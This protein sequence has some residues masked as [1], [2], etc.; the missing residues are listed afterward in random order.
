MRFSIRT[1]CVSIVLS[2]LSLVVKS[3]LLFFVLWN[4]I[5]IS[6]LFVTSMVSKGI[7]WISFSTP[8]LTLHSFSCWISKSCELLV[9]RKPPLFACSLSIA[10][11]LLSLSFFWKL[12]SRVSTWTTGDG[13]AWNFIWVSWLGLSRASCKGS[14]C[15]YEIKQGYI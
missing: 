7:K 6:G 14:F 13:D 2:S 8:L 10:C 4:S 3:A 1:V 5:H 11:S 12:C 9:G 15:C